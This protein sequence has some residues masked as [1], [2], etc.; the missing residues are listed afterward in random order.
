[1]DHCSKTREKLFIE[2]QKGSINSMLGLQDIH[3]IGL[4]TI[5]KI[6][7]FINK[8]DTTPHQHKI[9]I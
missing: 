5:E 8:K 6:H 7:A 9:D 1:M 4:G 3:G 2:I